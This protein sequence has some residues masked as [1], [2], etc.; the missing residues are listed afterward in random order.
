M[1]RAAPS[2]PLVVA[3][4][5]ASLRRM[6]AQEGVPFRRWRDAPR[7]GRFVVYDAHRAPA[8]QLAAGQTGLDVATLRTTLG[9]DPFA[10]AE[11]RESCR[12]LWRVGPWTASE[13]TAAC[14]RGELRRRTLAALR[15]LVVDAGGVWGRIAPVPHPYRT[16]F[17]FRFDHDDYVAADFEAV[18]AAI[19]GDETATTHFVCAATHERFPEAL[20]R[21]RGLDVGS[22]G[23]RHH[24][25]R[26]P[27]ENFRNMARGIDVLRRHGLEPRGYAAPHGRFASELPALLRRL[28]V[29]FS[30]EFG[31]A[32]DDLPFASDEGCDAATSY[33]APL[34]IPIHPV[35][36]GIVLEAA[37]GSA[38]RASTSREQAAE[39]V[40]EYFVEVAAAKH[41]CDELLF[42][43]G[44]PDG[45]LGRYPRVLGQLLAA[46]RSLPD[47]WRTNFSEFERW[48][49]RRSAVGLR[50]EPSADG[51]SVEAEH[52]P[53]NDVVV[54]EIEHRD[55][56]CR[57]PLTAPKMHVRRAATTPRVRPPYEV[58]RRVGRIEATV[59]DRLRRWLDWERT[60][61][62]E[63]IARRPFRNR[64]KRAL[65]RV[66]ER[67]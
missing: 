10:E 46:V 21:L 14:D 4:V 27:E 42:F 26:A 65:R 24:A 64:L 17:S 56:A 58:P 20:A 22:H 33:D 9:G 49:R 18:F 11:S 12:T 38:D 13:E 41:A 51:W 2:L 36:L 39:A 30:S 43:Y 7:A 15:D 8:P 23:Y 45:R 34:Q 48:W 16:A 62:L 67:R 19:A 37:A 53:P 31:L 1:N 57:V 66:K 25:Y 50:V 6:L 32:Y 28:G 5:P 60:T 59:R 35:C 55:G 3:D 63:E 54:L 52:L 61:P 29:P 40:A 47:V 44:H